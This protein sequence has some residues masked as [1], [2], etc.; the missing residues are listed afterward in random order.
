MAHKASLLIVAMVG[1]AIIALVPPFLS[2]DAGTDLPPIVLQQLR[3]EA[4][5]GYP[6]P[7]GVSQ[8]IDIQA[9]GAYPYRVEGTV[10]YR[11]LFGLRVASARSYHG[12]T[13]YDLAG[14]KLGGL[15]VGFILAE[16][17]LGVRLF[18]RG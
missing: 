1:L 4:S 12:A 7:P 5:R 10:V 11:S 14:L 2:P 18:R 17:L 15:V 9:A 8:V 6:L 16:G 3:A 13:A